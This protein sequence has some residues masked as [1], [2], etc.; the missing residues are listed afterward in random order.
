MTLNLV[1]TSFSCRGG[2]EASEREMEMEMEREGKRSWWEEVLE[3][4]VM[5][6]EERMGEEKLGD[7]RSWMEEGYK[8]SAVSYRM[9]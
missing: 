1:P 2:N 6:K 4:E 9:Y 5:K 7:L 8:N 3:E